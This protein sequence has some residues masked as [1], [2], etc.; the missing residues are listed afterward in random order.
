MWVHSLLSSLT[1]CLCVIQVLHTYDHWV[2]VTNVFSRSSHTMF[3]YDSRYDHG[4]PTEL[5]QQVS[6]L[7]RS[8]DSPDNITFVH[9]NYQQQQPE[10]WSCGVY[11]FAACVS[12]CFG[13]DPT[14]L[15]FNEDVMHEHFWNLVD[16]HQISEFP[17]W[18]SVPADERPPEI[19]QR[20]PKL[21]CKCHAPSGAGRRMVQCSRCEN[22]YH[23]GKPC[24][25]W[26][27][28]T[29]PKTL[30]TRGMVPATDDD[31][32]LCKCARNFDQSAIISQKSARLKT[33]I[34]I[35]WPNGCR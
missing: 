30:D 12:V 14:G 34:D 22:W 17:T 31:P 28:C 29:I 27:I 5:Q 32:R 4:V 8:E 11:A 16:T 20:L 25:P 18:L 1:T 13:V 10:I 9:R 19:R 33:C 7:L 21:H 35:L 26:P 15:I 2:C 3:V 24:L 6:S 23:I